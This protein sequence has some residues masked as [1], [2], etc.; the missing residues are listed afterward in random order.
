M[1]EQ[2]C[3]NDSKKKQSFFKKITYT[4]KPIKI[5]KIYCK[6]YLSEGGKVNMSI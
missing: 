2:I 6:R 5:K 4:K 3:S 1:E